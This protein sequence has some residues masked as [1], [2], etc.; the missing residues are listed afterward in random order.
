[1][2]SI[3]LI[4]VSKQKMPL[5]V[6][7]PILEQIRNIKVRVWFVIINVL[8]VSEI[9]GTSFIDRFIKSIFPAERK[10]VRHYSRAI[11]ILSKSKFNERKSTIPDDQTAFTV[12]EESGKEREM[13][14]FIPI[15]IARQK[16]L[17]SMS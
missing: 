5:L 13:D 11:E 15:K 10:I 6:L 1:M 16:V 8:A 14:Q 3:I 9:L 17:P 4:S 7:L 12:E 2:T